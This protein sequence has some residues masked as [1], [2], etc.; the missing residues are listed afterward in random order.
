VCG[1]TGRDCKVWV[2][3]QG[4]NRTL[5]ASVDHVL[6]KALRIDLVVLVALTE[7]GEKDMEVAAKN[8]ACGSNLCFL[9]PQP[10]NEF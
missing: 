1:D 3:T 6:K 10:W 8:V 4:P 5:H 7:K 9:P 2:G